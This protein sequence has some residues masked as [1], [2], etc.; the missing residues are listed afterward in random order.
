VTAVVEVSLGDAVEDLVNRVTT[1][2]WDALDEATQDSAL[3]A[4]MDAL[5][6]AAGGSIAPGVAGSLQ[7][8]A[9]VAGSGSVLVPWWDAATGPADAAMALSLL[10][11]AWDFD[12]THD[13]A[14]VHACSV[15]LPA[16]F[17]AAH[18]VDADGIRVLEGFVA[19]VEVVCRLSLALGPQYGVIRTAG[20]GSMGAAAAAAVA[21]GLDGAGVRAALSLALPATLS[22]T[23]RQVVEDGAISKRHQ[24]GFAARHGVTAAFL[25][26]AGI[27]GP[28]GWFTGTHGLSAAVTDT[29]AATR[30]LAAPGWEVSR[31]S[32]KPYPA[33]R[34]THAAV[35]AALELTGGVPGAP[36]V[37]R[38]R[39]HLPRGSAHLLVARPWARRGQPLVDAQF[40]VPWLVGA[41]LHAGRV[42]LDLL[43]GPALLDP[44]VEARALTVDVVQDQDAGEAVMTPVRV[45]VTDHA[46]VERHLDVLDAPGS[47]TQPLGWAEL[48]VKTAGCLRAAGRV[49]DLAAVL[50]NCVNALPRRSAREAF[51]PLT[52]TT[53]AAPTATVATAEEEGM[54]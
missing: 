8:Y 13:E 34:Y 17:A 1:V 10:I 43:A 16:A 46:G 7:A 41:A 51:L 50:E 45:V 31:L 29:A 33:C 44:A 15:A 5:G 49:A 4:V 22:P 52:T 32:M 36:D 11:H 37:A 24:P 30:A 12:D 39:V 48:R 38:A 25:A 42:D 28:T 35:W 40:S 23:T 21:L 2:R 26:R 19:G 27:A 47:P 9:A 18:A 53:T 3:R 54:R 14:V 20:L 6:I